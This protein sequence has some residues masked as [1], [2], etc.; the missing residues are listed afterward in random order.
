MNP[1]DQVPTLVQQMFYQPRQSP[2]SQPEFWEE[3]LILFKPQ[4][5]VEKLVSSK[6]SFFVVVLMHVA[7]LATLIPEF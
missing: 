4:Q 2:S 1:G 5:E 7:K 3:H 6:S